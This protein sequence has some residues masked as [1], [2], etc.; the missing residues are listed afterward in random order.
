M[1]KRNNFLFFLIVALLISC[2][3]N[4]KDTYATGNISVAVDPAFHNIADA[5]TYRYMQTYPEAKIELKFMRERFALNDLLNRKVSAIV[6]SRNL[7][8]NE[9]N[10]Y[11]QKI[12]LEP[13]PSY[14]AADALVFV[15]SSNSSINGISVDEIKKELLNGKRNLIF[16]GANTSNTD[17]I[18]EKFQ[19]DPADMK[20][21]SLSS[22][23]D[24]IENLDKFP[25]HIG[26][27]SLNTISRPF[28]ERAKKLRSM[29]KILPVS[30]GNEY[31]LPELR[32][33]K[34]QKYPFTRMLYFLT[35]E[36]YFGVAKGL[37]RYSCTDIGQKI[38]AKNGLQPFNLYKRY[39]EI[40]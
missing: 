15:V 17:Y 11:K 32:N 18:A 34:N 1:K 7:N 22:N 2:K 35:N 26:V 23:E 10:L 16:D 27:I 13:Q 37:I 39:V 20:Y 12:D 21:S 19:L 6:M 8:E 24:I 31:I 38:V 33:L 3:S 14:F 5:L 4:K 40:K 29:I 9:A 36:G 25:N 30:D 28:G